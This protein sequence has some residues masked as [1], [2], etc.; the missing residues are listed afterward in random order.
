[1]IDDARLDVLVRAALQSEAERSAGRQPRLDRAV[2]RLA[3]RIRPDRVTTRPLGAARISLANLVVLLVLLLLAL[4][5]AAYIGARLV[6]LPVVPPFG[7]AAPCDL[8]Q[9]G[10][11]ALDGPRNPIVLSFV[12]GTAAGETVI[13]HAYADG[14]YVRDLSTAGETRA[15]TVTG[16]RIERRRL[17]ED[18][19]GRLLGRVRSVGLTGGCRRLSSA[20]AS[21]QLS[22][23]LD[24]STFETSWAPGRGAGGI[25]SR[26]LSDDEEDALVELQD[27]LETPE[28]WLPDDAWLDPAATQVRPHHWLVTVHIRATGYEPDAEVTL[29]SGDTVVGTDPRYGDVAMP[30]GVEPAEFGEEVAID[31]APDEGSLH[32]C[33]QATTEEAVALNASLDP[34]ENGVGL[35]TDDGG[36]VYGPDVSTSIALG[37]Q[38]VYG[39]GYDCADLADD[40]AW[41]SQPR[42]T[43]TPEPVTGALA[44]VEPCSLVEP[45]AVAVVGGAA[46]EARQ[47]RLGLGRSANACVV[48]AGTPD[49][50]EFG[51]ANGLPA[52]WRAL[53][54]LYPERLS[55]PAAARVV[56]GVLGANL[57]EESL[58]NDWIWMRSCD[59]ADVAC[60]D[61]YAG[62]AAERLVFFEFT[63]AA[64]F[65]DGSSDF[66]PE[67][68]VRVVAPAA[69][70]AFVEAVLRIAAEARL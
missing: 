9:M 30:G 31:A 27:D 8:G 47:P 70:R 15:S 2:G 38:P 45:A 13:I 60:A 5:A 4:L 61:V 39:A 22:V 29:P 42:P 23:T 62:W 54:T 20:D 65:P 41:F 37:V 26:P 25:V 59:A 6:S 63:S 56:E 51:D 14:T 34:I 19:L 16:A 32:R 46:V 35:G 36:D 68:G 49:P 43:A 66:E 24:E 67:N 18:G 44:D 40:R 52:D 17:G 12:R 7:F 57:S 1:M 3:Q 58:V 33:G 11:L 55:Q 53:V 50:P 64:V 48:F 10:G 28:R 21:G 69:A